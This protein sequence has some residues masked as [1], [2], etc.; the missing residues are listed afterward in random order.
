VE[1]LRALASLCERP[2]P[3]HERVWAALDISPPRAADH[4]EIFVL[5]LP[6]YASIYLGEEGMLG[7]EARDRIAGFWRALR[8]QPPDE[9][10]HLAVLLGLY[11]TLAEDDG[12]Q[13]RHAGD[14]LL[15]EHILSWLPAYLCKLHEIAPQPFRAW[16]NLLQ[17][18]LL[19]VAAS[20]V[21]F[22]L[23][24]A[25]RLAPPLVDPRGD[26]ANRFLSALLA[27]VRSGLLIVREDLA[28]AASSLDLGLRAAERRFVLSALFE[29][30]PP[31]MRE[32]LRHEAQA[33]IEHHRA[34]ELFEPAVREYWIA[35]AQA[36]LNFLQ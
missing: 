33:W 29:Q 21:E 16:A 24:L 10:D 8:L 15:H 28:R 6:P 4:T 19:N 17:A 23:P 20:T 25:L 12:A 26:E 2:E 13:A 35:R 9:P 22:G 30:D 18:A 34:N 27:P 14:V 5:T 36:T 31:A 1:I 7:G 32:W 3:G 11:A